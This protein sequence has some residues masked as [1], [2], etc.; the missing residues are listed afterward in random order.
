MFPSSPNIRLFLLRIEN[1]T[2]AIGSR[3]LH[4]LGS[5]EVIGTSFSV[6][7]K[8]HY[9]SLKQAVRIDIACRIQSFLYDGS[10]YARIDEKIYR[11]ERTYL[12]G[13]FMELYLVETALKE[14]EIDGYP[15]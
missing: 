12:V 1:R 3:T 15:G 10:R 6:T 9:E 4:L 5:K 11:I 2:D 14:S 7:S 8:E 13:Q